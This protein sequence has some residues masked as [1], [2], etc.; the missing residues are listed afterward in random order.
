MN[1]GFSPTQLDTFFSVYIQQINYSVLFVIVVKLIN[2]NNLIYNN[3]SITD[4]L[5]HSVQ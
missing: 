1:P 3:D 5:I 2:L 4:C